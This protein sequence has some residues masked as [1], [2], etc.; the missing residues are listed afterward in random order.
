M[1]LS[2][3]VRIEV[4]LPDLPRE[5]Y[6]NLLESLDLEFTH[7]FGGC[8]IIRG[9]TGSY[10]SQRGHPMQD[11]INLVYT[12]TAF[13]WTEDRAIASRYTDRLRQSVFESLEEEAILIVAYPVY[14][15]E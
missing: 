5:Q 4:Y 6:Q 10:L 1:P 2:E 14:H 7:T 15:S 9:L 12:D 3:R 13:A 11:R 8:T